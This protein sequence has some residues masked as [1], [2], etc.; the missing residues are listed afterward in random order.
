M[1]ADTKTALRVRNR[2]ETKV[3]RQAIGFTDPVPSVRQVLSKAGY[4]PADE[5]ILIARLQHNTRALGLD[6]TIDLRKPGEEEFFAFRSDRNYRFTLEEQ[7]CDW[8][9]AKIS[10]IDLR[11]IARAGDDRLL[12]LEREDVADLVLAPGEIVTL[13]DAG[14]EHIR[15][16]SRLITVFLNDDAKK[17]PRGKYTTEEL[18]AALGVE[19][20]YL[21]NVVDEH[22]QLRTLQP[23]QSL[24]VKDGMH[25]FSQVPCGGSA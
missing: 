7:G 3:N 12:V 15:V 1:T 14:T 11:Y 19:A 18:I 8:A 9:E 22:G 2:F 21:L 10:E 5:C 23:G 16:V 20:G 25:F 17:I 13:S 6:E 4:D 24:R